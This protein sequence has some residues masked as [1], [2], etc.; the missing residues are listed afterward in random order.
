M[1]KKSLEGGIGISTTYKDIQVYKKSGIPLRFYDVK[2]IESEET[3]Q[4]YA[5]IISEYGLK[6]KYL[7]DNLNAI[8]YCLQYKGNGTLVEEME[9]PL[10]KQLVKLKI[11][12]LFIITYFP[13]NPYKEN[14]DEGIKAEITIDMEMIENTIKE[15]N[16]NNIFKD[17]EGKKRKNK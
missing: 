4:N 5:N 17:N 2:G 1:I 12:I 7:P 13:D 9:F 11:P 3:I 8:F 16:K 10:F 14:L 6:S 15:K